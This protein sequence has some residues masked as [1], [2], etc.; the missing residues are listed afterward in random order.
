MSP[1]PDVD[2]DRTTGVLVTRDGVTPCQECGGLAPHM[3]TETR[4][5]SGHRV[6]VAYVGPHRGAAPT[7]FCLGA[8]ELLARG[9]NPS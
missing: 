6:V 3:E 1:L 5:A 7:G 4:L 8:F 9:V 2:P